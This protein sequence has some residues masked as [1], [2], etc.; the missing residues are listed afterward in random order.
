MVDL[1][2]AIGYVVAHGDVVDRARL[3]YLRSGAV[4]GPDILDKAEFGDL[5]KGGWP[6]LATSAVP[7][8]D[9]TCFRLGELADL[10][11][12]GRPVARSALGWLASRQRPDGYWEEDE[13]L[14]SVAPAWA[15][16]G[17]HE[18]A[19]YL[20]V[21][22]AYWLAVTA[23]KPRYYGEHLDYEYAQHIALAAE[24]FRA[25]LD[26]HGDWPSYLAT[27]WL[28]CSLMFYVGMFYESAQ[29]QVILA[30]RIPEMAASDCAALAAT[31]RSVGMSADDWVLQGARRRLSQTQRH[32]GGWESDDGPL[33]DIHTTLTEIR[34]LR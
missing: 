12:L 14:A 23:P 20:T 30:D 17:D 34:A 16:P 33:F 4:P 25:T 11:A 18:A 9:A 2:A 1:D 5:P 13:S 6:A 7:S 24:A 3:S 21:N 15:K 27:G 10:G 26:G 28:G 29:V 22:A 31:M 19:L 32:D 8:V